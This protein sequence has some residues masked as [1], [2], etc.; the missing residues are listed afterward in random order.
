[1]RIALDAMGGDYAPVE[2]VKG[3]LLAAEELQVEIILVGDGPVIENELK[4]NSVNG[5]VSI[6]HAPEAIGM[7]ENPASAVRKK[8]N[9]SIVIGNGLVK[10]GVADAVVSAGNTG[11]AMASSLFGLGRVKGI[12]RPAIATVMPS[13]KGPMVLVD[14]GANVDC[15][16]HHLQQFAVM[17]SLYAER[18]L[19]IA[20]P[21]VGLINIG[22][23]EGKGNEL[24][25]AAYPILKETPN[26]NFIG[27]VESR[28]LLMG[29]CQVMVCDGFVGNV[30]LKA[31][32][33]VALVLMGMVKQGL[34]RLASEVDPQ[35]LAAAMKV[36]KQRMDYAEY[37]GAP[38]L[39]VNGVS[40]VGHGSSKAQAIKNA[41]RVAKESVEGGLVTAIGKSIGMISKGETL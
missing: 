28:E 34:E 10:K 40:I 37:G 41:I 31:S 39:G 30:L 38:L 25:Q 5:L 18:V 11:A 36:I 17:G 1:M 9:S 4:G 26:L 27:N 22:S 7:D 14:A 8:R 32:E 16:P 24:T 35:T 13:A 33:G 19:G 12:D 20:K 29:N 23:E 2:T 6:E 21:R 3:A 15:K